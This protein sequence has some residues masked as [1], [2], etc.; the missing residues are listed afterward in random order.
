MAWRRTGDK[1]LSE[2]MLVYWTD[3]YMYVYDSILWCV[4][5]LLSALEELDKMQD[6]IHMK[7]KW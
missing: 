1:P 2:A 5:M 3:A 6:Y 4:T 7:Q